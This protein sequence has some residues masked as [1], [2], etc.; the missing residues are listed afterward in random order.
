MF[1]ESQNRVKS[2]ALVHEILYTSRDIASVNFAA[3]TRQ[4]TASLRT[5]YGARARSVAFVIRIPNI[6]LDMD[7]AIPCGLIVNEL[8]SNAIKHAFR[9]TQDGRITIDLRRRKDRYRLTVRDNGSGITLPPK[10]TTSLGLEIVRALTEQLKGT[11]T[12]SNERGTVV[13]IDFPAL[14]AP[15]I[16]I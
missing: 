16:G 6:V 7:Q 5:S 9:K 11:V 2:M 3:Y 8:I 10:R 1:R 12:F 14:T 13:V 4:L 15:A